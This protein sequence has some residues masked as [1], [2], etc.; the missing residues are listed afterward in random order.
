MIKP[1]N[2]NQKITKETSMFNCLP[3]D[4]E[5]HRLN[6][7]IYL[8][9]TEVLLQTEIPQQRKTMKDVLKYLYSK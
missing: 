3:S 7:Q 8:Y 9:N 5:F 2:T 1:Y 6:N 4:Y